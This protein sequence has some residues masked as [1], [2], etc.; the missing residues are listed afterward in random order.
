MREHGLRLTIIALVFVLGS[1]LL[2]QTAGTRDVSITAVEGESWILHLHSWCLTR[3]TD[4][5]FYKRG[6]QQKNFSFGR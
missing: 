6:C 1:S 4:R 5:W 3:H 2:G